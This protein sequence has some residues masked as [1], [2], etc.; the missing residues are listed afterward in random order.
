MSLTD[1]LNQAATG[2]PPG[3]RAETIMRLARRRRTTRLLAVPAAAI[4]VAAVLAAAVVVWKPLTDNPGTGQQTA[5]SPSRNTSAAPIANW[6]YPSAPPV[7]DAERTGLVV[8]GR[9]LVLGIHTPPTVLPAWLDPTSGRYTADGPSSLEILSNRG[10]QQ[11][12]YMMTQVDAGGGDVI[13]YG[14]VLGAAAKVAVTQ[15][16]QTW[17]ATLTPWRNGDPR[18]TGDS[19]VMIF[20]VRHPGDP[21]SPGTPDSKRPTFTAYR[22]D[23]SVL[24]K[25]ILRQGSSERHDG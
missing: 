1:D 8:H 2:A 16:G 24:D 14:T 25:Q 17:S 19:Q 3:P 20:W 11:R 9:E 23:G 6:P 13:E 18:W 21:T 5:T 7:G 22:A 4:G 15:E 10:G 12:I